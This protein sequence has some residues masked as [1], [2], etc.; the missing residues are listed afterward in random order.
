MKICSD[1]RSL[2][3]AS[4]RLDVPAHLLIRGDEQEGTVAAPLHRQQTFV[5]FRCRSHWRWVPPWKWLL[6]MTPAVADAVGVDERFWWSQLLVAISK[7]R[8]RRRLRSRQPL[9][10]AR[11]PR[12]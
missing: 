7:L 6:E 9:M 11:I 10:R 4:G 3:G 5:C 1:C 2:A 12:L 8:T